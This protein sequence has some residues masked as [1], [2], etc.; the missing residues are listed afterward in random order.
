MKK[1]RELKVKQNAQEVWIRKGS[2]KSSKNAQEVWNRKGSSKFSRMPR[3][4]G[5]A[6]ELKV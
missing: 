1:Q 4:H 6:R 5:K 3:R 2:L